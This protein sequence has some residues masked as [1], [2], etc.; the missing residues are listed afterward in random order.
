MNGQEHFR[1]HQLSSSLF[2]T[3]I[4]EKRRKT[5][6][7]DEVI[8][9]RARSKKRIKAI[10]IIMPSFSISPSYLMKMQHPF[11]VMTRKDSEKYD[12]PMINPSTFV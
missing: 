5:F 2:L 4:C 3:S 12:N 11:H 6:H 7:T 1:C 10:H 8:P 9:D